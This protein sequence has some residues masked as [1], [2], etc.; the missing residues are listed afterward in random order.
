MVE[1]TI[2]DRLVM[3][4]QKRNMKPVEL[5]RRSGVPQPRISDI[6]NGKTESPRID[7]ISKLAEALNIKMQWL[8]SGEGEIEDAPPLDRPTFLTKR[9]FVPSGKERGPIPPPSGVIPVVSMIQGGEEG[10][11]EDAY[12]VGFGH[13]TI[14]RP[15]DVNDPN[16][17]AV[18]VR[19]QSMSP[20]YEEGDVV[21]VCPSKEVHSGDSAAVKLKSGA[22]MVKRVRFA[23]DMVILESVNPAYEPIIV[24]R[25]DID[26]IRKVVWK[27][28]R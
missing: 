20:K 28:E 5:S 27:K 17:F 16:A 14:K 15:Y 22:V 9:D 2:K 4:L 8:V 3:A 19:G 26:F 7:T 21:V 6:I 24:K 10:Y 12:P 23:G 25:E 18:E 13:R 11:W 1:F